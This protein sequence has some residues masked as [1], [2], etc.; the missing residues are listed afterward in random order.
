LAP[1]AP[2]GELEGPVGLARERPGRST[3]DGH[4]ADG[5][6]EVGA[7]GVEVGAAEALYFLAF[8]DYTD[9]TD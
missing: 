4:G 2:D 1:R 7:V 8:T 6:V 9:Y 5:F 3:R